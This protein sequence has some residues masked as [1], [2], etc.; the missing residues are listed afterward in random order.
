MGVDMVMISVANQGLHYSYKEM[1]AIEL[2]FAL[3][4][5]PTVYLTLE[6]KS[7]FCQHR[8]VPDRA[9]YMLY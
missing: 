1:I 7:I 2:Q 3:D 4:R 9:Q 8:A 6:P 5:G